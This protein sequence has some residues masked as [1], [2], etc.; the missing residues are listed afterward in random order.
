MEENGGPSASGRHLGWPHL[1]NRKWGHPRWRPEA[2]DPPFSSTSTIGI[3]KF[4]P[5]LGWRHFRRRHL[6]IKMAAP[7]VTSGG[8]RD[9]REDIP[10]SERGGPSP[11]TSRRYL[12]LFF[13]LLFEKYLIVT[14]PQAFS[15]WLRELPACHYG[16]VDQSAHVNTTF[17]ETWLRQAPTLFFF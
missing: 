15:K 13:C 12:K 1:R 6:W 11:K 2:G 16:E 10:S 5:C 8:R 3:E 4:S 7:Q 9:S 17:H 14:L